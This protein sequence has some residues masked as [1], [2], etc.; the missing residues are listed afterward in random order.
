MSRFDG[1][2]LAPFRRKPGDYPQVFV[3]GDVRRTKG[4]NHSPMA[5]KGTSRETKLFACV[6][7][8]R[9]KALSALSP[10][11]FAITNGTRGIDKSGSIHRLSSD[12][13]C[14]K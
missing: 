3:F 7:R 4:S 13:S 9:A 14:F 6:V 8:S 10:H 2:G 11:T 1:N 12:P 5:R